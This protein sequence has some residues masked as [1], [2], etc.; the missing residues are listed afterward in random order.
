MISSKSAITILTK[1]LTET[2]NS[3]LRDTLKTELTTCVNSHHRL[4]D[5]VINKGWYPAQDQP[6]QQLQKDYENSKSLT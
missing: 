1:V 5:I 4:S 2:T 6:M 3:Q